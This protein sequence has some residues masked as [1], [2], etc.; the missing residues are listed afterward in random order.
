LLRDGRIG[1]DVVRMDDRV[2]AGIVITLDGFVVV[3][4]FP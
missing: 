3:S 1:A 4:E 2:L